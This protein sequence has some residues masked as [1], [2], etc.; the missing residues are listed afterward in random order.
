MHGA[1]RA[2]TPV[3]G[4]P[5]TGLN[6]LKHRLEVRIV[7]SLTACVGP[8]IE[9]GRMPPDPYHRIN[10]ARSADDF[11]SRPVDDASRGSSLRRRAIGPIDV[12]SKFG[13]PPYRALHGRTNVDHVLRPY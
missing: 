6:A 3:G 9:I 12:S 7:P 13:W 1:V 11:S 8:L 2:A 4:V 5:R 10:A